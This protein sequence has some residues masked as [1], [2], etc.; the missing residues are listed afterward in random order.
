M[1][2]PVIGITTQNLH[3]IDNIPG[4]LP[5]SWMMNQRYFYAATAFGAV[6]WMIPLLDDDEATL[7]EIYLRLDGVLIPGGVDMAPETFGETPHARLGRT[8]PARDFV[9]LTLTTWCIADRKPLLGLCR[10]AQVIN[11]ALGGTLYQ[12]IEAQCPAAIKHDYFPT[13]GFSRDYLAH[14]VELAAG[15]RLAQ[16]AEGRSLQVNSMH[17]QGIRT[18]AQGLVPT[19]VAPDGLVEAVESP[20]GQFL[21]AVQWHP[22]S[23]IEHDPATRRLFTSFVEAATRV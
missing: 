22:E 14:T 13:A 5:S 6:P 11:V 20:N 17:H 3:A 4:E 7:R 12:D 16:V 2:R 8:D 21:V 23:L 15:S 18:L 9:E 10:G 1:T 19:A